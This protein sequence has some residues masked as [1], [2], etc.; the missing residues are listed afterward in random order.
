MKEQ[1]SAR[2]GGCGLL[3]LLIEAAN[4]K[5]KIQNYRFGLQPAKDVSDV[6]E[7]RFPLQ[8]VRQR[9]G[10]D[11]AR[12]EIAPAGGDVVERGEELVA[13]E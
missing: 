7:L 1:P 5:F 6:K 12:V 11:G 10:N 8:L 4:S 9:G 3:R 2:G 13:V